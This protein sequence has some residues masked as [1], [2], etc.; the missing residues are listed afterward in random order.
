[1]TSA[2][3]DYSRIRGQVL[4]VMSIDKKS[5]LVFYKYYINNNGRYSILDVSN[6][7]CDD[8]GKVLEIYEQRLKK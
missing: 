3:W 8:E 1:M 6:Y 5:F 7:N 4:E 2:Y